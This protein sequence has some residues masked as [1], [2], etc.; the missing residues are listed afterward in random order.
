[1]DLSKNFYDTTLATYQTAILG[2]SSGTSCPPTPAELEPKYIVDYPG[3]PFAPAWN[4]RLFVNLGA[5]NP[6]NVYVTVYARNNIDEATPA[7]I[8]DTDGR[9][10]L[11]GEAVMTVDGGPPLAD[12]SNVRV[13]KMIAADIYQPK[14]K[15]GCG[16]DQHNQSSNY[17]C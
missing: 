16:R 13:R 2:C 15:T 8:T 6:G 12:L 11:V 5:N 3:N 9:I 7:V 4:K 14:F 10:T 1:M 17:G